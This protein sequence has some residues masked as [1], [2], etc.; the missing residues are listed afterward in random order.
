MGLNLAALLVMQRFPATRILSLGY[1]DILATKEQI[2]DVFGVTPKTY[3]PNGAWH[4]LKYDLPETVEFFRMIGSEITCVDIHA[5]RGIETVVDLNYPHD[6][7]AFDMVIDGGTIEHCFNISQAMMN[8]AHAVKHGGVI[9]H[10]TPMSMMNHGFY[11]VCST[12]FHDFYEQ[13]GWTVEFCQGISAKEFF[14]LEPVKRFIAPHE[15]SIHFVARRTIM[16]EMRFPT[17]RKYINNPDLKAM[18]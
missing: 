6:L 3:V 15:C 9:F 14:P 13:N 7:G 17:Q 12:L 5:S 10:T 1:P 4:G 16:G 8:A 11:N 2:E 18:N